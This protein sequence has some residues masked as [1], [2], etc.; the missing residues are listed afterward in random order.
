MTVILLSY[1]RKK[2][3]LMKIVFLKHCNF[4]E[5][6]NSLHVIDFYIKLAEELAE[7]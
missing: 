5:T 4:R 7:G 2:L 3:T 1:K 6:K